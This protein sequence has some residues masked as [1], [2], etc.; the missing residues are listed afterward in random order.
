MKPRNPVHEQDGFFIVEEL[1]KRRPKTGKG[2]RTIQQRFQ[3]WD[4]EGI[5]QNYET[6]D[7]AKTGLAHWRDRIIPRQAAI[8][9]RAAQ[10]EAEPVERLTARGKQIEAASQFTKADVVRLRGMGVRL[11]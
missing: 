3:L 4:D 7:A 2:S 1:L 9:L 10:R 8:K 5:L 11:D 6:L